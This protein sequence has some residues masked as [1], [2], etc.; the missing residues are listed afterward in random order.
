MEEQIAYLSEK[1]GGH[2]QVLH[3]Q[4]VDTPSGEIWGMAARDKPAGT[5][6]PEKVADYV[7]SCKLYQKGESRIT[8]F[9]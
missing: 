4:E 8:E 1:H 9:R 3:C 6:A 2:I 7:R 5:C